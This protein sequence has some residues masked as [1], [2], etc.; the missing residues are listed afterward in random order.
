MRRNQTE[1]LFANYIECSGLGSS[2]STSSDYNKQSNQDT[3]QQCLE[4]LVCMY[5]N[6]YATVPFINQPIAKAEKDVISM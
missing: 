2:T 5:A 3:Q 1:Q 6:P 4:H